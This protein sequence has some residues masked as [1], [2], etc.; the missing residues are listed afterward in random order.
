MPDA[1]Q[2]SQTS[3]QTCQ[4]AFDESIAPTEVDTVDE[5]LP[6]LEFASAQDQEALFYQLGLDEDSMFAS[7][8]DWLQDIQG[9]PII[10]FYGAPP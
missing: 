6:D 4:I 5:G 3:Q 10:T 8:D 2:P 1:T 9:N 7:A